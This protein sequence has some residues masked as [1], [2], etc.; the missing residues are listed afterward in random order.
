MAPSVNRRRFLTLLGSAAAVAIAAEPI[1]KHTSYFFGPWKP[2]P[3]I[4][5]LPFP[6][7]N[8]IT[9]EAASFIPSVWSSE[10]LE[11]VAFQTQ[12]VERHLRSMESARLSLGIDEGLDGSG[13]A[14]QQIAELAG[15]M[16]RLTVSRAY[17][18]SEVDPRIV[19]PVWQ[20]GRLVSVRLEK[21]RHAG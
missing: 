18:F 2:A 12:L 20:D 16:D 4:Y 15:E 13:F 11:A 5:T 6:E 19:Y 10:I 9:T 14:I 21:E 1:A 7:P 17:R 8:V 3:P